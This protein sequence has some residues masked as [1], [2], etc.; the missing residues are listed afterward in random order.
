MNIRFCAATSVLMLFSIGHPY[1][2]LALNVSTWTEQ[3]ESSPMSCPFTI[4]VRPVLITP[5]ISIIN[6]LARCRKE[7]DQ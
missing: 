6:L 7:E 2:S 5:D 4:E 1:F 3:R